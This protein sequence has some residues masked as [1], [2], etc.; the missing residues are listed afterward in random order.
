MDKFISEY[1]EKAGPEKVSVNLM[2][3]TQ[4]LTTALTRLRDIDESDD[5]KRSRDIDYRFVCGEILPEG[6][7]YLT[8]IEDHNSERC[9][10]YYQWVRKQIYFEYFSEKNLDSYYSQETPLAEFIQV[11]KRLNPSGGVKNFVDPLRVKQWEQYG[12][13]GEN[14]EKYALAVA[15]YTGDG[16]AKI[17]ISCSIQLKEAFLG[18]QTTPGN[19]DYRIVNGYLVRALNHLPYYWGRCMRCVN[20]EDADLKEYVPGKVMTWTQFSSSSKNE[21]LLQ[22]FKIR[23]TRMIIYSLTGRDISNFSCY[24]GER[25]ILFLPYAHFIVFEHKLEK[26]IHYIYMRQI[27]LGVSTKNVLWVDDEIFNPDWENKTIMEL[28]NQMDPKIK[29]IPKASTECA[30]SYLK[31]YWGQE[32][33]KNNME[34][35]FRIITD[36]K[37]PREENIGKKAGVV[38]LKEA[39]RLGFTCKKMIFTS[40][41]GPVNGTLHRENVDTSTITVSQISETAFDFIRFAD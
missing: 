3:E 39:N 34:C 16:S 5:L 8:T 27:D 15:L 18:E 4:T 22:T 29:F 38:L 17:N 6:I 7:A 10:D 9:L 23:N 12:V 13:F 37:R 31:S 11:I 30:V 25:E 14:A 19:N 21:H 40:S 28:A 33:K 26:G 20:L 35:Q 1:Q 2:E 41:V 24:A 32:K 36:M